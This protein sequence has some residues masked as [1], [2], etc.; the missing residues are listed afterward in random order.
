MTHGE[1]TEKEPSVSPE[2]KKALSTIYVAKLIG[3]GRVKK[4]Q[5]RSLQFD[6]SC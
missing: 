5:H 6:F 3:K 1:E 2:E 4:Y